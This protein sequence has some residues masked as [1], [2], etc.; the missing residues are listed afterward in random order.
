MERLQTTK[1]RSM[2]RKGWRQTEEDG[3]EGEGVAADVG[4]VDAEAGDEATQID[5]ETDL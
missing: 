4:T 1:K 3:V 5:S 2:W